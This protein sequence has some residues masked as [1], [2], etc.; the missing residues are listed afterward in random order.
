MHEET[1]M[2]KLIAVLRSTDKTVVACYQQDKEVTVEGVRECV[3]GNA[4]IESNKRYSFQGEYQSIH[5][6][7]D[8]QGRVYSAVTTRNY[9]LRIAFRA[10][11]EIM[12]KFGRDFGS[13]VAVATEK[14]L[15][16]ASNQTMRGIFGMYEYPPSSNE[17][18][19]E[20]NDKLDIVKSRMQ[21]SIQQLLL[22]DEK[23][24]RI[25][26]ATVQLDQQSMAFRKSSKALNDQM[27]WR[28]W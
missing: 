2:L 13:E 25:E 21:E 22:N 20:V 3:A 11:H 14:S 23:L 18:I 5:Y 10:I 12:E 27:W 7:V 1:H 6:K 17:R 16:H 26:N 9:P 19:D 8:A 28:M 4:S 15:S 24:E